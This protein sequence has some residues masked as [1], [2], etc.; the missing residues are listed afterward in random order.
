MMRLALLLCLLLVPAVVAGPVHAQ[1]ETPAWMAPLKEADRNRIRNIAK[2][3]ETALGL[4]AAGKA[5]ELRL[6]R[7]L[8]AAPPLPLDPSKLAGTWRC[9]SVQLG[10]IFP[11]T[12]NPFFSCRIRREAGALWF[13]KTSGSVLRRARLEPI[14]DTRMLMFGAYR[15]EGD[16]IEPYGVDDT[17]DEVGVLERI[18]P[19]RLR[20]EL[21]QPR[22]YNSA[23]HEVIE[24]VK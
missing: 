18:G 11:I 1:P 5:N 3:R 2:S 12:I 24:L 20:I 10:G 8:L 6:A 7:E 21:P 15:A 22:A 16:K 19:N 9:R 23:G 13:D 17:H 4:A 14:D